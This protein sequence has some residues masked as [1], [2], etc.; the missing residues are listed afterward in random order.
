MQHVGVP[1]GRK[2]TDAL[3]TGGDATRHGARKDEGPLP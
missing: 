3:G 1:S 2:C